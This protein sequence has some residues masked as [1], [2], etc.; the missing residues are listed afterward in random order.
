MQLPRR[1]SL[2]SRSTLQ[3]SSPH[4]YALTA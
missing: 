1:A 3:Q 2:H 4:R